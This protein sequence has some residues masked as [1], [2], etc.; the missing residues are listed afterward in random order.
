MNIERVDY[1]NEK[2]ASALLDMLNHYAEDP[3]GGGESL[4]A[5]TKAKLISEMAKRDTVFSFLAWNDD[6]EAIGIVNCVEGF[7]TFAA[8]PLCNVHDIA[9]REGYRGQGIAQKLFDAV[10]AE[11]ASRGCCKLTLE[12]LSGNEPAR[13]SYKKYGFK[14]Y[15]LDP[16]MGQAEFWELK[17]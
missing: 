16:E 4:S 12:V 5:A 3:M 6:G 15:E 1:A 13:L 7:S 9:V 17:I 14:P 10:K 2:H 11:A 8:K